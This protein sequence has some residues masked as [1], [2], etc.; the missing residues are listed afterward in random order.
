MRFATNFV[1]FLVT[2]TGVT[3]R[4]GSVVHRKLAV[5]PPDTRFV[6]NSYVVLFDD[7]VTNVTAKRIGIESLPVFGDAKVQTE[8]ETAL[9]GISVGNVT[10]ALLNSILGDPQV[11]QVVPVRTMILHGMRTCA[12]I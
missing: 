6:A 3:A 1:F 4:L 12:S 2:L 5:Y 11:T 7:T 9:K 10:D 8:Y